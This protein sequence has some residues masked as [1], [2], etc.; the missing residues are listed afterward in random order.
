M[1]VLVRKDLSPSQQIVQSCHA[2]AEFV[3]E[4]NSDTQVSDWSDN[5]KTIVILGVENEQELKKWIS[6]IDILDIL[7]K[8][9]REPD[10]NNEITAV[11]TIP[12]TN[13]IFKKLRLL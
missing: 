2:V 4:Y 11:A 1:Y 8:Y 3:K 9:F 6:K 13:N 10:R 7:Y 5:H 12:N